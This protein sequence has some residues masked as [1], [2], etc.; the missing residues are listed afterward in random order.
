MPLTH[1]HVF[2]GAAKKI[3]FRVK[4]WSDLAH[5]VGAHFYVVIDD[6]RGERVSKLRL[7]ESPTFQKFT[8]PYDQ[9]F[10]KLRKI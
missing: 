7:L 10:E 9:N 8:K 4:T 6:G 2:V 3:G 1:Y 5:V